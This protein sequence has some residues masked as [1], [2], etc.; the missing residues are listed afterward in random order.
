MIIFAESFLG[1]PPETYL[2]CVWNLQWNNYNRSI[3][4]QRKV[5][6]CFGYIYNWDSSG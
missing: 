2:R 1:H 3:R 6:C 5:Q 4:R